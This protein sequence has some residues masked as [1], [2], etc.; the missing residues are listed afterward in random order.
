MHQTVLLLATM[1]MTEQKLTDLF[2]KAT[3]QG[4]V[5]DTPYLIFPNNPFDEKN[6]DP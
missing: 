5:G 6:E 2:N 3:R 4:V 1:G